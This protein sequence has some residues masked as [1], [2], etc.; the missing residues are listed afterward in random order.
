MTLPSLSSL[1]LARA[2]VLG[3]AVDWCARRLA[4]NLLDEDARKKWLNLLMRVN[5]KF[6][7]L[8]GWLSGLLSGWLDFWL[9]SWLSGWLV[10]CLACWVL[11]IRFGR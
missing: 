2:V 11:V 8:A 5:H 3:G 1:S 6:G 7:W 4:R 9:A 10:G